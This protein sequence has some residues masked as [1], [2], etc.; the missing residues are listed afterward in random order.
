M[1]ESTHFTEKD[2]VL[3]RVLNEDDDFMTLEV[4]KNDARELNLESGDTFFTIIFTNGKPWLT[5]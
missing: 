2:I 1:P 5:N 4:I 3:A